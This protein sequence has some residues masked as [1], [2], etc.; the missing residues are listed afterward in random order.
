MDM[1]YN[2]DEVVADNTSYIDSFNDGCVVD[3]SSYF[4]TMIVGV[5]GV[6]DDAVVVDLFLVYSFQ[7]RQELSK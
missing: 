3:S 1:D 7:I 5:D 2:V 6:H 4:N